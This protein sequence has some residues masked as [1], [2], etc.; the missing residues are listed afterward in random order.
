VKAARKGLLQD[1]SAGDILEKLTL[2]SGRT[3]ARNSFENGIYVSFSLLICQ[4]P[5]QS[6]QQ[7]REAAAA[8][9]WKHSSSTCRTQQWYSSSMTAYS[10]SM[11][12]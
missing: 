7:S 5:K 2:L 3:S 6:L 8:V 9:N 11:T 4:H 1:C 10:S 12:A